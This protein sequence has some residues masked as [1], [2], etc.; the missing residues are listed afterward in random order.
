MAWTPR[1]ERVHDEE[2]GLAA[3][4]SLP[5][6]GSFFTSFMS[7]KTASFGRGPSST[8]RRASVLGLRIADRA[9]APHGGND[10]FPPQRPSQGGTKR[11][12]LTIRTSDRARRVSPDPPPTIDVFRLGDRRALVSCSKAS[13]N[14]MP[15]NSTT[16]SANSGA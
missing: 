3:M 5:K 13:E 8:S 16:R 7:G 14:R 1:R 2:L 15:S 10:R 9:S 6:L 12:I 4:C 11:L